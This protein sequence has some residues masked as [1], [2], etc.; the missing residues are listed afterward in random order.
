M[1]RAGRRR[2][3]SSRREVFDGPLSANLSTNTLAGSSGT[4]KVCEVTM[5]RNRTGSVISRSGRSGLSQMPAAMTQRGL[6]HQSERRQLKVSGGVPRGRRCPKLPALPPTQRHHVL[7]SHRMSH[8]SSACA[9]AP[10][11]EE[12]SFLSRRHG[13]NVV[14]LT[15]FSSTASEGGLTNDCSDGVSPDISYNPEL[16]RV[17]PFDNELDFVPT[18][19]AGKLESRQH[20]TSEVRFV[21]PDGHCP[22]VLVFRP[23]KTL[24]TS[25]RR[26]SMRKWRNCTSLHSTVFAQEHADYIAVKVE[27]PLKGGHYRY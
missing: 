10:D 9:P 4:Q 25:C 23:T 14:S 12:S 21:F 8:V 17:L 1:T 19:R 26:S 20:Q 22:F 11:S 15:S 5:S 16:N 2:S 3:S 18:W 13:D 27:G 6:K 24:S 7:H